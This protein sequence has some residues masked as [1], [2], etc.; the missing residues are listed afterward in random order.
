VCRLQER[1]DLETVKRPGFH[2]VREVPS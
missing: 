2:I 1:G